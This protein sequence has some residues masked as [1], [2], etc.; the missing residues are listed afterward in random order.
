MTRYIP[1][2]ALI[3]LVGCDTSQVNGT[4]TPPMDATAQALIENPAALPST[5]MKVSPAPAETIQWYYAET[6]E[7]RI[8][9]DFHIIDLL[10]PK[11]DFHL[12]A[13]YYNLSVDGKL[14]NM[15]E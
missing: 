12:W 11:D 5:F 3:L 9:A 6:K 15:L 4:P 1:V 2:L 14:L 10:E 8:C 7:I 13:R